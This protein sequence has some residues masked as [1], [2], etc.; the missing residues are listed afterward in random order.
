MHARQALKQFSALNKHTN[1]C[2]K[3]SIGNSW[4]FPLALDLTTN[5]FDCCEAYPVNRLLKVTLAYYIITSI[6]HSEL[7]YR[8]IRLQYRV[9]VKI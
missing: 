1:K 6:K 7:R 3:G 2:F 8:Y 9:V 4:L 5:W